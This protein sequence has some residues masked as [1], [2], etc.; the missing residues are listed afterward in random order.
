MAEESK[1][2]EPVESRECYQTT[3]LINQGCD[4]FVDFYDLGSLCSFYQVDRN[5]ILESKELLDLYSTIGVLLV[6][7]K[8]W[9]NGFV[10]TYAE[11]MQSESRLE[12]N[13]DLQIRSG[14][15]F[16]YDLFY[17]LNQQ[18]DSA[19]DNLKLDAF[20]SVDKAIQR[21]RS[22]SKTLQDD[23]GQHL[24]IPSTHHWWS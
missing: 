18:I 5:H 10:K 20:T 4:L 23:R 2:G 7:N 12:D 11:Y 13:N 22:Q 6:R 3:R 1:L 8:D 19:L 9:I 16:M 15:Q 14:L 24:P 17:D 21:L